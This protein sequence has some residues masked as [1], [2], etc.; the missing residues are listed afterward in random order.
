MHQILHR[1]YIMLKQIL[2]RFSSLPSTGALPKSDA[3]HALGTLLVRAAKADKIYLLEEI[4][5]IDDLL[6]HQYSIT[7]DQA[8]VLRQECETLDVAIPD[9]QAFAHVLRDA[10]DYNER[11]ATILALWEVVFADGKAV[12]AEQELLKEL[13]ELLGVSPEKS[14][15]LYKLA[16][17]AA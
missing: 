12:E 16:E 4:E 1:L 14:R 7:L 3:P 13:E 9:T 6:A 17:A 10:I 2:S 15:E 11:V 5:L 8:E